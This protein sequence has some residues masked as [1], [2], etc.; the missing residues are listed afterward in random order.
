MRQILAGDFQCVPGVLRVLAEIVF[1]AVMVFAKT[2]IL[3]TFVMH[4]APVPPSIIRR[5]GPPSAKLRGA[6]LSSAPLP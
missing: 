2:S 1:Q 4:S 3:L 5:I 6:A